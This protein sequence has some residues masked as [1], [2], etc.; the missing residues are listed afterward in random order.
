MNN[1]ILIGLIILTISCIYLFYLYY[2]KYNEYDSM[3][4][5]VNDLKKLNQELNNKLIGLSLTK[6]NLD[7]HNLKVE[8]EDENILTEKEIDNLDNLEKLEDLLNVDN[9]KVKN[10]VEL[11]NA[12]IKASNRLDQRGAS[13][14]IIFPKV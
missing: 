4:K 13:M 6:H 8:S 7:E 2:N 5:E 9:L 14:E 10:L 11:H 1:Y 3:Y 12:T